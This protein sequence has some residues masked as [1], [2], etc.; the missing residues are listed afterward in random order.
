MD[1]LLYVVP[2]M[3]LIGLLYTLV[4]FNWVNK[5]D[6]GNDRMREISKHIAAGAMAF[7]K[8]EW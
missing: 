2:G 8:A 6:A 3:A 1:A 7:L 5:Q 4:Q